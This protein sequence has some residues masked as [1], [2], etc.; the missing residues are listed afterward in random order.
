MAYP[1][2][3]LVALRPDAAY[4]LAADGWTSL[5][6][7]PPATARPLTRQDAENWCSREGWEPRLLDEVPVG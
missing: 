6:A 2:G 3:R 5:G 1:R 7:R 4:V